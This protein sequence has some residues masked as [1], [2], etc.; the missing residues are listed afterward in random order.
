MADPLRDYEMLE[1]LGSMFGQA[2]VSDRP[3]IQAPGGS[4][5]IVYKARERS[6]NEIV[7]VKHVCASR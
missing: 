3:L 6:T 1:E 4:F 2:P 5:G 7:A